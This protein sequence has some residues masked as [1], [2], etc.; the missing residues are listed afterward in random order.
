MNLDE[1]FLESCFNNSTIEDG[2]F[3]CNNIPYFVYK[4]VDNGIVVFYVT[5][6]DREYIFYKVGDGYVIQ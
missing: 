2:Y 6:E 3:Y 1:Y 4:M 5:S